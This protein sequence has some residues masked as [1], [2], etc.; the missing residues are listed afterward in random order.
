VDNFISQYYP[1]PAGA[2][3]GNIHYSGGWS[4]SGQ[5]R[6]IK[7]NT[8]ESVEATSSDEPEKTV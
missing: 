1:E 4:I 7:L 6:R 2:V 3:R 5:N 8:I